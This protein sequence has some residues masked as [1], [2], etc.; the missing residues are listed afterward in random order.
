M[1]DG[2]GDKLSTAELEK[3]HAAVKSDTNRPSS[4]KGGSLPDRQATTPKGA[5]D[6]RKCTNHPRAVSIAPPSAIRWRM[7]HNDGPRDDG[8]HPYSWR[9]PLK[10]L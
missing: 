2:K 8:R 7:S 1:R 4:A 5:V 6:R 3:V 9:E 10:R